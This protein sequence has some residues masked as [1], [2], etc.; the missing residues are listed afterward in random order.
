MPPD[1]KKQ[2]EIDCEKVTQ[3][4]TCFIKEKVEENNKQGVALGLS[5][6]IDSTTALYLTIKAVG[7]ERTHGLHLYDRESSAEFR[8]F[9]QRIADSQGINFEVEDITREI[10]SVGA[11][12]PLIIKL[13]SISGSLNKLARFVLGLCPRW[14]RAP[15]RKTIDNSFTAKHTVRRRIL[16]EY[17]EKHNLLVLGAVNRTESF[18]G[19]FTP[20]GIDDLPLEPILGLYKSQVTQLA[21]YLGVPGYVLDVPPSADMIKGLSDEDLAGFTY[22]VTDT[23]AYL[24]ENGRGAEAATSLGINPKAYNELVSRHLKAEWKRV[25]SHEFPPVQNPDGAC[26]RVTRAIFNFK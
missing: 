11:Y 21:E 8:D 23:V 15:V 10:E 24:H 13:T 6:G 16:E 12:K 5:G 1:I 4:I 25:N 2:M 7:P 26:P 19:W 20:G 9:T 22:D 3:T 17:A 18:Y 14:L